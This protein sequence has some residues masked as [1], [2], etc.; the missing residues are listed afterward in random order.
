MS[1]LDTLYRRVGGSGLVGFPHDD[2]LREYLCQT[3]L[4]GFDLLW[5]DG[6]NKMGDVHRC[7]GRIAY[8]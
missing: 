1:A 5:S 7:I 4:R 8:R 3:N 2:A 6:A